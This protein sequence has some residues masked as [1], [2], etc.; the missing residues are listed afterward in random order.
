MHCS[1]QQTGAASDWD[2]PRRVHTDWTGGCWVYLAGLLF[3]Q[4]ILGNVGGG[5]KRGWSQEDLLPHLYRVPFTIK[6]PDRKSVV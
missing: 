2:G 3:S 6:A 5:R 1:H 4:G